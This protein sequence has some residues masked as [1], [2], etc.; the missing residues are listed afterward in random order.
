MSMRPLSKS[1][2][3]AYR[4]CERR[5]WLE[6]HRHDLREDSA[7]TQASFRNGHEVGTLAQRIYDP[8]GVGVAIDSR[9][10]GVGNALARTASLMCTRQPV[11][12]AGFCSEDALAFADVMLPVGT[13]EHPAWRMVEVKSSLGLKDYYFDDVAVQAF[14]ARSAGVPL[15]SVALAHIDRNWV[16]QGDGDYRGLLVERDVTRHAF[17]RGR[18]VLG[19]I[20][21]A[22]AV[23]QQT[24]EPAVRTGRHCETP[25]ACGFAAHCQRS[26][27]RAV[28]PVHWLPRSQSTRL[29]DRIGQHPGADLRD[30]VSGHGPISFIGFATVQFAVPRWKGTRPYQQIPFQFGVHRLAADGTLTHRSFLDLSGGDP[31]LGFA[32][33]LIEACGEAGPVFA[34]DGAFERTR[35]RELA[36]RFADLAAAL[37]GIEARIV[38]LPASVAPELDYGRHDGIKNGSMAIDAFREAIAPDTSA[39]RRARIA[40][41]LNEHR[42]L[43]TLAMVRLWQ[44]LSG[45]KAVAS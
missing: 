14:I 32:R 28:H 21:R 13:P 22:Q 24:T 42:A 38:D 45:R 11:F 41:Q 16:Y 18:E 6:W 33:A 40:L 7:M 5:L 2:L 20:R 30:L 10:E 3:M 36:Q 19:W 34:R 44:L 37:H 15:E 9:I 4:Q 39:A 1:R 25:Y 35:I 27:P 8:R 29:T 12:E 23:V 17:A 43:D 26:E 31:S